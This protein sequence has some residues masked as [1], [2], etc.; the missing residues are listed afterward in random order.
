MPPAA[1]EMSS[2]SI[3]MRMALLMPTAAM[4]MG[5]S[6]PTMNTSTTLT[7]LCSRFVKMT[8][9]ASRH[10]SLSSALRCAQVMSCGTES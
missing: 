5:P 10:T 3:N 6:R 8:G 9:R 1:T 4:A 7:R 2:T